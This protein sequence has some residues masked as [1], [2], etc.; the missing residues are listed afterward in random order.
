VGLKQLMCLEHLPWCPVNRKVLHD[1]I[2]VDDDMVRIVT[3]LLGSHVILHWAQGTFL[4][5]PAPPGDTRWR[6]QAVLGSRV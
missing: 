3:L 4:D 1:D 5:H 2:A 6:R